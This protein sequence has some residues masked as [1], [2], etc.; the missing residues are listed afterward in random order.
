MK[1]EELTKQKAELEM[2]MRN[3]DKQINKCKSH[4][5]VACCETIIKSFEDLEVLI[6]YEN[7]CF[8]TYCEECEI[9]IDARIEF[10]EIIIAMKDL[11]DKIE[12]RIKRE[13]A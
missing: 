5:S 2:Q 9:D 11:K 12:K 3:L 1:L 7:L 13:E 4:N 6:P 8:E 10:N